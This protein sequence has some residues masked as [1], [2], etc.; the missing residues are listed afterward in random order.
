MTIHPRESVLAAFERALTLNQCRESAAAA[1]A[2]SLG[3]PVEA[4][5]EVVDELEQEA[6]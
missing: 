1:V 2:Q 5:R 3:L 4:V 6:A